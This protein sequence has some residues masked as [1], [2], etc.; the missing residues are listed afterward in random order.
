MPYV[1]LLGPAARR[2]KL[3]G[4]LGADAAALRARLRA[5]VGLDIGGRAPESIALSIVG[6]V[7]AVLAGRGGRRFRDRH[8]ERRIRRSTSPDLLPLIAILAVSGVIAGF[9]AGLLGVGGGIVT[10]PVLEYSL[11]FADV[12]EEYRMH[13][14][15]ATSLA[16]IIPTSISSAR[17]HH[18]RGAVDWELAKRWG[19]PMVIGAFAGSLLAA[20]APLAVL[21]G[22]FGSVALLI[23]LKMLLPLDHLRVAQQV[24]RGA[25]G[26]VAR[27]VDRRRVG[28]HGIGGGTLTVP[29]LN[30]CG[31]PIHRAV[32][33]AAFFGIFISI[34]GTHRLSTGAAA[35]GLP[36][37]TVGFVSLVGLAI[38][39]PGSMLTATLGARV[40]HTLSRRRLS[41]AFGMFL[42][43]VGI[44][45]ALSRAGL[46]GRR[47]T[48]RLRRPRRSGS[49]GTWQSTSRQTP[50]SRSTCGTVSRPP[51]AITRASA[52]GE[53][54]LAG[55]MDLRERRP[56]R[57]RAPQARSAF[58]DTAPISAAATCP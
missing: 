26:V 50:R 54:A 17:T 21:A 4:D 35:G 32:G 37:A 58:P 53:R 39:A 23:A 25:G 10:V 55:G 29:T 44:A 42:L 22:V 6:E 40:A 46:S 43:L 3:L 18:A 41:Q 47:Q 15:V 51:T 27:R 36:W 57:R 20:R 33:T 2:E 24:P 5:P 8:V 56:A 38:I 9:A 34:P 45:D 14:A 31:Y 7:H 28:D 1:G 19:V 30:L 48:R 49:S 16:A 13:V 52:F 11:R 12:P